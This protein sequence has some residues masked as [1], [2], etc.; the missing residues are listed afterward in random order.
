MTEYIGV[1]M[2]S[3]SSSSRHPSVSR[4]NGKRSL[5]GVDTQRSCLSQGMWNQE[6][7]VF[8]LKDKY[9]KLLKIYISCKNI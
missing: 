3:S 2:T 1:E 8:L 6:E 7:K 9:E 4:E 5:L